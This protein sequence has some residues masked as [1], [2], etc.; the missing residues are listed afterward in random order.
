[1]ACKYVKDLHKQSIYVYTHK[2]HILVYM[3]ILKTPTQIFVLKDLYF[4]FTEHL[5]VVVF[6]RI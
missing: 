1:M 4:H 3:L 2:P 5:T 6:Q